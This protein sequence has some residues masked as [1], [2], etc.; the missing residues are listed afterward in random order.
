MLIKMTEQQPTHVG[1]AYCV[2]CN[3]WHPL[4][5]M[6]TYD[7]SSLCGQKHC[8]DHGGDKPWTCDICNEGQ[9]CPTCF[10]ES[11]CCEAEDPYDNKDRVRL[12]VEK[13]ELKVEQLRM[14]NHK[15]MA[16][17]ASIQSICSTDQQ[18]IT[19]WPSKAQ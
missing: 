9:L 15:L 13:L 1:E 8:F 2:T 17:L 10:R 7:C 5:E 14:D 11:A 4:H 16:K 6:Q 19:T 18:W 12:R 3:L